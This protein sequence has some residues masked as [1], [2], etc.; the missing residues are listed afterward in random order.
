MGN[1]LDTNQGGS[2]HLRERMT[3][4]RPGRTCLHA[5]LA[6]AALSA[7]VAACGSTAGE[8]QRNGVMQ[9][10]AGEPSSLA[11]ACEV[12]AHPEH[13]DG[14]RVRLRAIV[15]QDIEYTRLTSPGCIDRSQGGSIAID[16][17]SARNSAEIG[18]IVMEAN[19]RST[20]SQ[21]FAAEGQFE[22][23]LRAR[24]NPAP[25]NARDFGPVPAL[26]AILEVAN[27]DHVRL[28]V[29]P[30]QFRKNR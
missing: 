30:A 4:T 16:R 2:T 23:V 22:G 7:L 19:R 5:V 28:V 12:A 14:R 27:V 25:A 13:F 10:G 15:I 3:V 18:P 21:T 11:D 9:S 8:G 26:V 6:T 24:P 1:S 20:P 29:L 17:N